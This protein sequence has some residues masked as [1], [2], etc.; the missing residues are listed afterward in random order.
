MNRKIITIYSYEDYKLGIPSLH[1]KIKLLEAEW[2]KSLPRFSDRE[3]LEIFPEA[4]DIIQEKLA[5]YC[6]KRECL[7]KVVKKMLNI[8]QTKSS[9]QNQ[10][11]WVAWIKVAEG[12]KLIKI[13]EQ[14]TRLKRLH[15]AAQGRIVFKNTLTQDEIKRAVDA[16]IEKVI[17][18]PLKKSGKVLVGLCP[19]HKE[20]RPSFYLYPDTNS[21]YCFG[22]RNGGNVIRLIRLLNGYTFVEAVQWLLKL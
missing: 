19:F 2:R 12:P 14:I 22:C 20:K 9:Q 5:K 21:F 17:N 7:V 3:L 11:F 6:L 13:D 16:P 8:V 4:K 10:W 1:A 15:L 18:I